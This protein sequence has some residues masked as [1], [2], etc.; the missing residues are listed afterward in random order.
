[1]KK[2]KL[3]LAIGAV[4]FG[5]AT[6]QPAAAAVLY[7]DDFA[8]GTSAISGGI[9]LAGLTGVGAA[10]QS[11]FNT[12]LDA[13]GWDAVIFGE[14][15]SG[16]FFGSSSSLSAWVL[17]GGKLIGTTWLTGGLDALLEGSSASQNGT[18]ITTDANPIFAGLGSTVSLT[19]PGWGVFSQGWNPTGGASCVGSLDSGGCAVIMGNLGNTYLNGPLN[20]TYLSLAD[21]E[22]LIA[23]ELLQLTGT[24]QV[25]EPASLA[26][27]CLGLAAIG[28]GRRKKA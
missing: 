23:N 27:V 25:P 8:V 26:L 28:L 13:G 11:D 17:G 5:V 18:T 6:A 3:A 14:Q 15:G 21:G 2:M 9:T 10:N 22:R 4:C 7:W 20:D 16:V 19:N 24:Q 12:K 1:M